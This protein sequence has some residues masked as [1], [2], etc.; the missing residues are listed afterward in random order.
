VT[1]F[2]E[3]IIEPFHGKIEVVHGSV[4]SEHSEGTAEAR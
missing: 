3:G 2:K 4:A 1:I